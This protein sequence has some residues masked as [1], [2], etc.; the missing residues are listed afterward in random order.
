MPTCRTHS[1]TRKS[2]YSHA[3][4][5]GI[6]VTLSDSARPCEVRAPAYALQVKL[7]GR[8]YRSVSGGG[9]ITTQS[10]LNV[11]DVLKRISRETLANG[12]I[13]SHHRHPIGLRS[14]VSQSM[15]QMIFLPSVFPN[16][17]RYH[18]SFL[19]ESEFFQ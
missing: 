5:I 6:D 3:T 18:P 14:W 17:M 19:T 4:Y 11:N 2:G 8:L 12:G 10:R 1:T 16:A 13:E 9:Q 7:M 15:Q